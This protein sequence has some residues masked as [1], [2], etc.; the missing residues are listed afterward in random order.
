MRLI[1]KLPA[2]LGLITH[3]ANARERVSVTASMAHY[4][5]GKTHENRLLLRTHLLL[6]MR[7][8]RLHAA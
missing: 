2:T 1:H 8:G 3:C 4:Y 7:C 5:S 6:A